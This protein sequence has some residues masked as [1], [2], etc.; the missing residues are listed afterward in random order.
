MSSTAAKLLKEASLLP[1][2]EKLQLVDQ[3]IADLDLPDPAVEALWAGE[4]QQR[5]A[6]IKNGGMAVKP[7]DEVLRKY[8]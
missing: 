7:L 1:A 2:Q 6:L 8:T 4:A 5:S 3:L